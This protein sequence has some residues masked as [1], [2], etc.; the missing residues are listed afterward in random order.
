MLPTDGTPGIGS[1]QIR[2]LEDAT[3]IAGV[4]RSA[5][6]DGNRVPDCG[7][8]SPAPIAMPKATL[9]ETSFVVSSE[10]RPRATGPVT[11]S[12]VTESMTKGD[13]AAG[14]MGI[15]AAATRTPARRGGAV[16][17]LP[18]R[19]G[20][21]V[22]GRKGVWSGATGT[23]LTPPGCGSN[24]IRRW[25]RRLGAQGRSA[26]T[27][28][29]SAINSIGAG[30]L[31]V[32]GLQAGMEIASD[33]DH[34]TSDKGLGSVGCKCAALKVDQGP[35]CGAGCRYTWHETGRMPDHRGMAGSALRNGLDKSRSVTVPGTAGTISTFGGKLGAP[36]R[37]SGSVSVARVSP[38]DPNSV[39]VA[40]GGRWLSTKIGCQ[41]EATLPDEGAQRIAVLVSSA[42]WLGTS[43]IGSVRAINGACAVHSL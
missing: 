7:G 11:D 16:P 13:E 17:W 6:N 31:R 33:C 2:L 23:Q 25:P 10:Q 19:I 26:W 14:S 32:D 30:L 27:R 34:V 9:I 12:P 20:F 29:G 28:P 36:E 18:G 42:S 4:C 40:M 37:P 8:S 35:F 22:G 43:A 15:E 24:G 39:A 21:R 41:P 38:K 3:A 5:E 1:H